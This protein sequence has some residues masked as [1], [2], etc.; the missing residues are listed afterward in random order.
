MKLAL[1]QPLLMLAPAQSLLM[2]A[3]AQPLL[4]LEQYWTP[5]AREQASLLASLPPF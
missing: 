2:L 5:P 1:A 4:M 3:P